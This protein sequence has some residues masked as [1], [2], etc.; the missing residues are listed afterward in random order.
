MMGAALIKLDDAP[1]RRLVLA[2][3]AVFLTGCVNTD[4]F[5]QNAPETIATLMDSRYGE[6]IDS[7]HQIPAV[8]V[9]EI[10][11]SL[12]R[13]RVTYKTQHRAGT[14]VVD[15]TERRLY[16]VQ[17]GGQALRYAIGVG[18]EDALN[19][20]GNATI[21]RKEV[22]PSWTPTASMIERIPRYSAYANGMPGGIDNPLGARALYLY[23]DS[24]DTEFRI[25]GT[26]EPSSIGGAVSSGCIRLFNHDIIDFYARVPLGT[27]V[28]V[29]Q[30]SRPI[31]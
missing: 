9:S 14:V 10:D 5:A 12:L 2:S 8:D 6:I 25:H 16:L 27:S 21:G 19:F 1:S 4:Q 18:R 11:P 31:A 26:N 15:I 22:W 3:L 30:Q 23:R 24:R 7:G 29:V 17:S 13:T 20:Q 28:V